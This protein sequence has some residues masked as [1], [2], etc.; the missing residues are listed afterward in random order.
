M[1]CNGKTTYRQR[2]KTPPEKEY[3]VTENDSLTNP[4]NTQKINWNIVDAI[5][6]PIANHEN[7][8]SLLDFIDGLVK[9]YKISF[10]DVKDIYNDKH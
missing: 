3:T 8:L 9:M 6:R 5:F 7:G 10:E 2:P 1:T 4:F